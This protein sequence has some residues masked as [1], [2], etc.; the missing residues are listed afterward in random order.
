MNLHIDEYFA[1]CYPKNDELCS[2]KNTA[3]LGNAT[4]LG[5]GCESKMHKI[6]GNARA[7]TRK[8][9]CY[10]SPFLAISSTQVEES[11][12]YHELSTLA[13]YLYTTLNLYF[14]M[15]KLHKCGSAKK[16]VQFSSIAVR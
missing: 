13:D 1:M 2:P 3:V 12:F 7:C 4:K 10:V 9:Y 5:E 14:A 8:L 16:K 11:E 15:C 6:A